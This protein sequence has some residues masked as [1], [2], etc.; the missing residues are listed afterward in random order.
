LFPK[1]APGEDGAQNKRAK[2]A[3]SPE[4]TSSLLLKYPFLIPFVKF[5]PPGLGLTK[6]GR[7]A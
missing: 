2:T 6:G 1:I 4:L 7:M 5:L 3:V